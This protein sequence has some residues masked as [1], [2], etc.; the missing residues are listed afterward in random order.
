ML[1]RTMSVRE[2]SEATPVEHPLCDDYSFT[3]KN[4]RCPQSSR[5]L[6]LN[7]KKLTDAD[8]YE[9]IERMKHF[10]QLAKLE[11]RFN[12]ITEL[13]CR[14]ISVNLSGLRRLDIRGNK[15]KD[16]AV[17]TIA[18]SLHKLNELFVCENELSDQSVA[19]I[20]TSM[21][22]LSL[23]WLENNRVTCKGA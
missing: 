16:S 15:L 7:N 9:P 10:A 14:H 23:I 6:E 21:K 2:P 5:E 11:L 18:R 12:R 1:R 4:V 13:T 22:F 3:V 8:L 20:V 19:E 17:I